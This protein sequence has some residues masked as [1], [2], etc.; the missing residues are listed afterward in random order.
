MLSYSSLIDNLCNLKC[1]NIIYDDGDDDE[2]D[3][4]YDENGLKDNDVGE[5][6]ANDN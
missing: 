4:D 3:D 2:D 6:D 5:G 1:I